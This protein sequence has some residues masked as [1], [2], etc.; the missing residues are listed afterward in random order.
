MVI[1]LDNAESILDPQG[2]DA[3]EIYGVVEE[4]GR[5]N[6]IWLCITSRISTVPP[7]CETLEIPTLSMEAACDTFYRIYKHGEQSD[8]VNNILERLDFHPLSITLLATVAHHSKWSTNRLTREWERRRTDV[9]QTEH[10]K[11][12]AATIELSLASPMFQELGPDARDLLGIVAFFPQGVDENNLDWL[13]PAISNGTNLFDKFCILSL[14]YRSGDF[15]TMLAPL[16]DYLCPKDPKSSLL[17]GTTKERYFTKMSVELDPNKP[18]FENG[19]WITSEDVNVEHLLDVFT[20]T[21]ANPED[22]WDACAN[23]LR[24]IFWHKK[25]LTVLKSKIEGLPDDHRSKPE[26]LL[27]LSQLFRSVGNHV[28][29]KRL[30]V[31]ASDLWRERGDG[32][33]VAQTLMFLAYTNRQL[34]LHKEGVLQATESFNICKQIDHTVGQAH[35][36]R[37]LA[38]SLQADN[39]L[40]AAEEAASQAIDLFKS[41]NEQFEV[42]QVY[43][44]L[45]R[46]CHCKNEIEEAIK[47][48]ETALQIASEFNWPSQLFWN[49]YCLAEMFFDKERF[50]EA[51]LHAKRA[52]SHAADDAFLLGRGMAL[53]A[54]FCY[55]RQRFEEAKSEALSAIEVFEKL[56]AALDLEKC[57]KILRD[58]D[59]ELNSS[60]ATRG[61]SSDGEFHRTVSF[62]TPINFPLSGQ[63]SK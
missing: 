60:S 20:S 54:R 40:D 35:S 9:L 30:L 6:N 34:S 26:C 37:C 16:R 43:R 47:H 27:E 3:E 52:K 25:R 4:L 61:S 2:T 46:I 48:F 13:F 62:S 58:A 31:R 56:G 51:H 39:Q 44:I 10:N 22:V 11:S 18:G 23:F 21:N 50:D 1:V 36:L 49:N 33:R 38:W 28:E 29:N 32:Y 8:L 14:T 63:G 42:C 15:V 41:L 57:R 5:Y 24:H 55:K 53:L 19:R 17:L 7:D 45:A 59:K 12:L